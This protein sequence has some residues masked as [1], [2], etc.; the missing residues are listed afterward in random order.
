M[1]GRKKKMKEAKKS[2]KSGRKA[3]ISAARKAVNVTG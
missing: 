1:E 2:E 3:D